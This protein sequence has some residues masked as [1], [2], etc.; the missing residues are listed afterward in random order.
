MRVSP[1]ARLSLIPLAAAV[2]VGCYP[3]TYYP[4]PYYGY[5]G[6]IYVSW[7]FAGAGC[8][9]TPAV[10]NVTVSVPND[11]VPIVPNTFAC[12]VG[13][14]PNQLVIYNYNPGS[15]VVNLSGLDASG[16]VIWTGSSTVVVNGNV[17]TTVNLQPSTPANGAL[18]S[19]SF[20]AAVGSFSPPC[21]ASTDTDP[22]RMDSV[23]LYVDGANSA[24][25]TYDC[26]QGF[27]GAQVNAPLITPGSH[28]LQLVAYQAGV[29]YAFAQTAPVPV[30]IVAGSPTSQAFTLGWLVGG[31]G[32]AWTYPT[33]GACASSVN[34]VTASFS[35]PA[36]TGYSV[37]GWPCGTAVAPFKRLPASAGGVT[38][39]L[40]V[41]A[42]G[43]PPQ[44]PVVYSGTASAVTIQ[45]GNFYDGTSAT[46]V[47]VPLN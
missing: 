9:Q 31:T 43:A 28:T 12:R 33:T 7:T 10:A 32:V 3:T 41:S 38:Y 5:P 35:G 8:A 18:L 16:N 4:P 1:L 44:S 17:A 20:A 40:A 34:S 2:V 37:A 14:A 30:N 24:A 45:P 39:A 42:L 15:Y 47:T 29:S 46:V 19:W 6:N 11:P 13:D 36:G 26:S 23:A 22:D 21:T 25:A 27:G